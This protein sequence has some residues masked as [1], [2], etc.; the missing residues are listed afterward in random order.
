M[1]WFDDDGTDLEFVCLGVALYG[2]LQSEGCTIMLH[3][4]LWPSY[5]TG[6]QNYAF[7]GYFMISVVELGNSAATQEISDNKALS[8]VLPVTLITI[9]ALVTLVGVLVYLLIRKQKAKKDA[10][11]PDSDYSFLER[12]QQS[13]SDEHSFTVTGVEGSRYILYTH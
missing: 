4:L 6:V 9:A 8:I 1:D 11:H 5:I 2:C 7:N 10:V 3:I 13:L 12:S